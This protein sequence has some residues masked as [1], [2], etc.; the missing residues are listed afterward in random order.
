MENE[1]IKEETKE[2][3]KLTAK[4]IFSGNNLKNLI[5]FA[6]ILGIALIFLSSFMGKKTK[7]QI[8]LFLKR[9]LR[10]MIMQ[11][12]LRKICQRLSQISMVQERQIF[13]LQ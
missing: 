9:R 1:D 2:E 12:S 4:S 7:K 8:L 3:K 6:G 10:L 11:K 13:L 5:I